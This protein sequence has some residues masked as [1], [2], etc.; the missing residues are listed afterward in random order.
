M[1]PLMRVLLAL[2]LLALTAVGLGWFVPERFALLGLLG[3]AVLILAT[4]LLGVIQLV[5]ALRERQ[6]SAR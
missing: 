6:R 4:A 2:M 1:K 5:D 3:W